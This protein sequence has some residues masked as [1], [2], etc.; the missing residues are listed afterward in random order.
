LSFPLPFFGAQSNWLL[1]FF[2]F[3]LLVSWF[4][5]FCCCLILVQE[6]S[7]QDHSKHRQNRGLRPTDGHIRY[8]LLELC[9]NYS[10]P[11]LS[12]ADIGPRYSLSTLTI[13]N[14]N[15]LVF[16]LS[17]PKPRWVLIVH[18]LNHDGFLFYHY[19]LVLNLIYLKIYFIINLVNIIF[20]YTIF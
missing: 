12:G 2:W 5:S 1:W 20:T 9:F 11:N 8:C 6:T 18:Y 15:V 19:S 10:R 14:T 4:S 7:R 3:F 13:G 16:N 17:R